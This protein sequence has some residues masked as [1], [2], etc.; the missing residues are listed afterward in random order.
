MSVLRRSEWQPRP[1]AGGFSYELAS[2][3]DWRVSVATI[4][5]DGPF[6]AFPGWFRRTFLIR[7]A[8][9]S[10]GDATMTPLD[11]ELAYPGDPPPFCRLLHGPVMVLN[12]FTAPGASARMRRETISGATSIDAAIVALCLDAGLTYDGHALGALDAVCAPEFT[13]AGSGTMLVV[14]LTV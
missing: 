9:I 2:A 11:P 5:R 13:V 8:G 12:V 7:G 10:L 3:A 14:S 6:T 4:E 1:W